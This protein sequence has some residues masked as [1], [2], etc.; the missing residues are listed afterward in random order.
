MAD[1]VARNTPAQ[2]KNIHDRK[3]KQWMTQKKTNK[4]ALNILCIV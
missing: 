1:P 3:W 2:A 4:H